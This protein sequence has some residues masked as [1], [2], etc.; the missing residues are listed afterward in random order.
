[1]H[2]SQKLKS[3]DTVTSN[4]STLSKLRI[5]MRI[6]LMLF[7]T[8]AAVAFLSVAYF[9]GEQKTNRALSSQS[10]NTEVSH[11]VQKMEIGTL[12]MRRSEKDFLLRRDEKYIKKYNTAIQSVDSALSQIAKI[13]TTESVENNVK[14]LRAGA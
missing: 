12:Q 9:I 1:M 4:G 5:G 8:I 2:I 13:A 10:Q 14:R 6:N 7:V 3:I 11:L